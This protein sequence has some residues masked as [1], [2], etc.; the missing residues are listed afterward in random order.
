M[1]SKQTKKNRFYIFIFYT[2]FHRLYGP[3]LKL[4]DELNSKG[5]KQKKGEVQQTS[6]SHLECD[7]LFLFYILQEFFFLAII[8]RL[9]SFSQEQFRLRVFFFGE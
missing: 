8:F 7:V 3:S 4:S 6:W 9:L 2:V 1:Q 5:A